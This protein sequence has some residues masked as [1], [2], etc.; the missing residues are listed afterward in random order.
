M[1]LPYQE[2]Q[3]LLKPPAIVKSAPSSPKGLEEY[4]QLAQTQQGSY[5]QLTSQDIPGVLD[6]LKRD[7]SDRLYEFKVKATVSKLYYVF[8]SELQNGDPGP[9]VAAFIYKSVANEQNHLDKIVYFRWGKNAVVISY[10]G[11]DWQNSKNVREIH[12]D[13]T[14]ESQQIIDKYLRYLKMW[15]ERKQLDRKK[16]EG[17]TRLA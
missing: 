12:E 2:L 1:D 10:S 11:N 8:K 13:T 6:K 7:L 4:L 16:D 5:K 9:L 17:K 15:R 14:G 3:N